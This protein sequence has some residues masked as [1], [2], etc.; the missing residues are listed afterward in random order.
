[1]KKNILSPEEIVKS[2]ND[3]FKS[4]IFE[5]KIEKHIRGIKKTEYFHICLRA[6]RNIIRNLV[7]HLM[8]LE[9]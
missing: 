2:F 5:T 8:K 3:E 4:K 6:D 1:M 7:Q 9:K